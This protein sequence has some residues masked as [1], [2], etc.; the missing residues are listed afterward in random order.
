VRKEELGRGGRGKI[1]ETTEK[2]G[3][4]LNEKIID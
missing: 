1:D 3:D 2:A 4:M